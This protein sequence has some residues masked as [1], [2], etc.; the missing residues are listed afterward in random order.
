MENSQLIGLSRQMVLRRKMDVIANNLANINTAGYK[1]DNLLFEE[2][3]MPTARMNDFRSSDKKI[4]YVIDNRITHQFAP[5]TI[6]ETGNPV[7]MAFND[8]SSWFAIQAPDGERYT[9]NGEF[10]IN[11]QGELVTTEGYAVLG[12]D[13]PIVFTTEDSNIDIARDGT[14]STERGEIGRVR[15]VTFANQDAMVKEGFSLFKHANPQVV[16]VPNI[17]SGRVESSNVKGVKEISRMIAV[18]R[19]YTSLANSQ[20]SIQD[21][22][23]NAIDKL[24]RLS[25]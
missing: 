6:R 25:A 10:D 18:T 3:I 12:Q 24:G 2:Y 9:R 15:V 11:S 14:I 5:G 8:D 16:E 1:S 22:R 23:E 13:G 19:A 4:S 17:L 20:K 7:N 21:L